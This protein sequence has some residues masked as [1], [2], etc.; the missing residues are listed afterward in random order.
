MKKLS[1]NLASTF[2]ALAIS[3]SA[4]LSMAACSGD[5]DPAPVA[6]T[7]VTL[8]KSALTLPQGG[9]ETLVHAVQPPDAANKAVT[10]SSS[11]TGIATVSEGGLV[12]AVAI[13][14]AV[15]TVTAADGGHKAACDVSVESIVKQAHTTLSA[16]DHS[17]AI[18]GDGSL[19]AWGWNMK[20][21]LGGGDRENRTVPTRVGTDTDWVS[22][23][24]AVNH[25]VALKSDGS[26]WTCGNN[27]A[28]S[29]LGIGPYP[30]APD[31]A[32]SFVRV[33]A[34]NDWAV[35]QP[36]CNW[37]AALKTDGSL[38][39]WGGD[40]E[41]GA[42]GLGQ[43]V[44]I[45]H[46]PTRVG[47]DNDWTSV[48]CGQSEIWAFK[49]D[50]SLWTCGRN[51]Y[52]QLGLGDTEN[53]YGLT[54]VPGDDWAAVCGTAF[55]T[56]AVKT[57]G[58]LWGWGLNYCGQ[59]GNGLN[60]LAHYTSPIRV[61]ND[62]NDWPILPL[63]GGS[64]YFSSA[65]IKS[66][67]SLWTWGGNQLGELGLGDDVR[68]GSGGSYDAPEHRRIPTRVGTDTDWAAVSCGYIF[69]MALKSDGSLWTT[70][71]N[72]YG[73]LGDDSNVVSRN[74]LAQIGT[75]FRVPAK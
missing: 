6:V 40:E 10:W 64:V 58:S 52:G 48:R 21:Q 65:A 46:V 69:M 11:D 13:G 14:G 42:M 61:L 56:M 33:G 29:N 38:W 16:G 12:T 36:G 75:G 35:I 15:I 37:T 62:D 5:D 51:D 45:A 30:T 34:D 39:V 32:T 7:S 2:A 43:G 53:R 63:S 50:G 73:N 17:L 9:T 54:R 41:T 59:L 57:D 71:N 18:K 4:A 8:N 72:T 67:G 26:L 19:W 22:V 20:G 24:A 47:A 25:S 3:L 28:F 70:G 68:T 31:C 74:T 23:A 55:H 49:T 44:S 27:L 66:G 1:R 60:E